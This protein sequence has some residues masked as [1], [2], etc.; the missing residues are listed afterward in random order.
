MWS[1]RVSPERIGPTTTWAKWPTLTQF[2]RLRALPFPRGSNTFRLPCRSGGTGRRAAFRAQWAQARG[3]SSPPFGIRFPEVR[4]GADDSIVCAARA[5]GIATIT[6]ISVAMAYLPN[7]AEAPTAEYCPAASPSRTRAARQRSPARDIGRR[8]CRRDRCRCRPAP[9]NL[10]CSVAPYPGVCRSASV[11]DR[12]V[13]AW[14]SAR[15]RA[16]NCC[17]AVC[18]MSAAM[19][20]SLDQPSPISRATADAVR[21]SSASRSAERSPLARRAYRSSQRARSRSPRVATS[22]SQLTSLGS[23][24]S[25]RLCTYNVALRRSR[26]WSRHAAKNAGGTRRRLELRPS[27]PGVRRAG[28]PSARR[29]AGRP[30]SR[31][32]GRRRSC[33]GAS[34]T[35]V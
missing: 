22:L 7:R 30:G 8:S 33:A 31:S 15:N 16:L 25:S 6:R 20:R 34:S 26:R 19:F 1:A 23:G 29:R 24:S 18:R 12:A 13:N 10:P 3:G 5:F 17:S 35:R 4:S 27:E 14:P 2:A 21:S 9:S 28:A 32:R 11:D